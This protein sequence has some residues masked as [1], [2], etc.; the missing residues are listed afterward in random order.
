VAGTAGNDETLKQVKAGKI[1]AVVALQ[2]AD[3]M[4]Q[5]FDTLV[6]MQADPAAKGL[7]LTVPQKI[8]TASS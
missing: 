2:F 6:K 1:Y 5:S 8:I 4:K 7:V 3:D